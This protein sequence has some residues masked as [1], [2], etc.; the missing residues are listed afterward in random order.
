MFWLTL[1]VDD[2]YTVPLSDGFEH[3]PEPPATKTRY[4]PAPSRFPSLFH[5]THLQL[6]MATQSTAPATVDAPIQQ[7]QTSAHPD[8]AQDHSNKEPYVQVDPKKVASYELA[9]AT[10]DDYHTCYHKL[11]PHIAYMLELLRLNKPWV[12]KDTVDQFEE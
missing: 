5:H 11:R 7:A 4:S 1:V 2:V 6:I 9:L 12:P 8:P 10:T 3:F